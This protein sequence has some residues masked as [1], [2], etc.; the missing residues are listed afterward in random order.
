MS[1]IE[2][3]NASGYLGL[4]SA[5][6]FRLTTGAGADGPTI[7][8]ARWYFR[9]QTI[10]VAKD[11]SKVA[12]FARG[13]RTFD[14]VRAWAMAHSSVAPPDYP[15]LIW[16]GAPEVARNARIASTGTTLLTAHGAPFRIVPKIAM[17]RSY[18]DASSVEFFRRRSVTARGS[19]SPEAFV[20]R[21]MWPEDFRLGPRAPPL[22]AMP[23]DATPAAALR[24]L[25]RE[26]LRGGARAPFAAWTLWQRPNASFDW[27]G[28]AVLA[29][30]VNG[31]QGDDDEAHGGHFALVTGRIAADGAIGDWLVN[32]FYSLD[33]ESEKGIIASPVPLDSYIGDLNSGQNWYRPSTMLVAVLSNARSAALV[34]SAL[35]RVYN[36]FYRHQLGYYH[37]T[38]NCTSFSIDTLRALGWDVPARG[39]T[40]RTL[41]WL[42]L[43]YVAVKHASLQQAATIFDY[44][45][46]DQTRLLPAVAVEDIFASLTALIRERGDGTA[47]P[48][49]L[50]KGQVIGTL[51]QMLADDIDALAFLRLP[52]FPSSRAFGDAAAISVREAQA[53]VPQNPRDAQIIPLPPR[54]FPEMLRDADLL[55]RRM[56]PSDFALG[57][58]GALLL[59]GVPVLVRRWWARRSRRV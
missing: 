30:I 36:Q 24:T 48:F 21:S 58:W 22:R 19:N 1:R 25:M 26:E 59:I 13:L 53:R 56:R 16:V 11:P 2:P 42:G 55:P 40:S 15:P 18:Y 28:R 45:T 49:S 35:G 27:T 34:Q 41:A 9:E 46:V 5:Q 12:G 14:D 7:A 47:T 44:L 37:P 29:F 52:Q 54:P 38:G 31:A 8:S 20:I 4:F 3:A 39:A 33:V 17:N 23:T 32:N 50:V 51:A 43:P 6:D 10:A 57:V